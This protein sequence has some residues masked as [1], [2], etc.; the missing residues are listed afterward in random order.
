MSVAEIIDKILSQRSDL[1]K[2]EILRKLR[3]VKEKTGGLITDF[4]LL[5]VIAAEYGVELPIKT[6]NSTN[7]SLSLR[8]LVSGLNN[9][10]VTGRV[11]A[12]SPVK[13]F[14]SSK[15]G[16]LA[17]VILA[18]C[19]G[20]VRVVL[21]DDH[22]NFVES[23]LIQAGKVVRFSHA[24]TKTGR[25]CLIELHV[26]GKS[27]VDINPPV[28]TED[29][30]TTLEHLTTKINNLSK[31]LKTVNLIGNV[32]TI[33]P[34]SSFRRQNQSDGSI[35]RFILSDGTGTVTVVIWNDKALEVVS[36]L[37][38]SDKVQIINGKIRED[39]NREI[40]VHVDFSSHITINSF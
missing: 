11:V 36:F 18:D 6:Y 4:T 10:V 19:S 31:T 22:V 37:K 3:A 26:G 8:D 2:D 16:K 33:F 1:Q 9:V 13:Y 39:L 27:K 40:E 38:E 24:Y 15:P 14:N 5:H 29:Y 28:K 17:S 7:L 35:L 23:D 21:W 25:D 20:M 32:K 34:L 12:V 30:P